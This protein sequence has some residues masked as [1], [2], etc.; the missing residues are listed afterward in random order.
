MKVTVVS[1]KKL[2]SYHVK[3]Y[4]QKCKKTAPTNGERNPITGDLIYL[5]HQPCPHCGAQ[6]WASKFVGAETPL[7]HTNP[8][9]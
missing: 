4:C 5:W 1:K 6:S 7:S 3:V 8:E 9:V 2:G